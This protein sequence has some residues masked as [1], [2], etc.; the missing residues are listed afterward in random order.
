MQVTEEN[1]ARERAILISREVKWLFGAVPE[2]FA[3]AIAGRL[4]FGVLLRWLFLGED[5]RV[6]RAGEIV[7]AELRRLS[8]L[9]HRKSIFDPDPVTMAFREGKRT[10]LLELVSY[11]NLD[12]ITVRKMM[13]LDD[14]LGE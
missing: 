3:K 10:M 8:G 1:R 7:L 12:E 4:L 14:G 2:R 6:H 9:N 13:E 5:G 11:L